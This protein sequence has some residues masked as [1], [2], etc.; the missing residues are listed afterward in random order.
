M[1]KCKALIFRKAN[2]PAIE[3][4]ELPSPGPDEVVVKVH[5]SGVSIGTESSI[6]SGVRT[7]NGTFP[8]VPGYMASGEVVEAGSNVTGCVPGDRVVSVGMRSILGG[9][10]SVWGGHCAC[11]VAPAARV[12]KIPA[13]VEMREAA[14]H[15]MPSV[16]LNAVNM[17]GVGYLDTVAIQGQGLIGQFFGQWCRNRGARV[18]AIEPDPA[19]AAL[20]RKYVTEDVIDPSNED[21]PARVKE[22]SGGA[23]PSVVVEAT[24]SPRLIDNATR[25]LSPG[26][27]M[28]FLSWYPD[29]I[30]LRFADFH[31]R[32]VTAFFPCGYGGMLSARPVLAALACGSLRM[33]DNITH[34]CPYDRA[35]EGYRRIIEGDRSIM[36][37]AVDWRDA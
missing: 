2:T 15:V 4:V 21:V 17:V 18:I 35:P 23:G 11:H 5:Y 28:V 7:F 6:F 16:G 37:M 1:S 13:G 10:N 14:L 19:R 31:N 20:S 30:D 27:K 3:E 32:Q 22:L 26:G 36:G 25:L 12:V 33:A 24:A 8:L 29:K 34:V 9:I